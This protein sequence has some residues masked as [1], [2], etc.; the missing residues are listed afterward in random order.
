MGDPEFAPWARR[1]DQITAAIERRVPIG[2]ML[3]HT[4]AVT[5]R[6]RGV[7]NPRIKSGLFRRP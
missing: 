6:G 1:C 2:E 3:D 5:G 7:V 4:F